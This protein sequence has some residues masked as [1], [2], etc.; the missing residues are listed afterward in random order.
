[1]LSL[2]PILRT[3]NGGGGG[4]SGQEPLKPGVPGPLMLGMYM[5]VLKFLLQYPSKL[6]SSRCE[7]ILAFV[8]WVYDIQTQ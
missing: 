5:E 1:M 4:D 3:E 8:C 7:A 2:Y 6:L